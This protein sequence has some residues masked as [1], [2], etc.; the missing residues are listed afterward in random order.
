M[1][2]SRLIRLFISS[3]FSD[4]D[5]ER[6]VLQDIVIPNLKKYCSEQGW[7][8]EAIDLRWGISRE[9]ALHHKTIRICL[10]AIHRCQE[11]SPRPNFF[12]LLGQRYGWIPVPETIL[13]IDM[14]IILRYAS[15]K[16]K[17][18]LNEWYIYDGNEVPSCY[19]FKA[20][21]SSVVDDVIMSLIRKCSNELN[22]KSFNDKYLSSATEKEIICGIFEN[23]SFV[24]NVVFYARELTDLPDDKKEIFYETEYEDKIK[25]LK[26]II[27]RKIPDNQQFCEKC[28]YSE[29]ISSQFLER[30]AQRAEAYLKEIIDDEIAH[31][32]IDD[33]KEE[34]LM[35]EEYIQSV[36]SS[37]VGFQNELDSLYSYL[38]EPS[39]DTVALISKPPGNGVSSLLAELTYRIRKDNR[40]IFRFLG[41]G[42]YSSYGSLILNSI[43]NEIGVEYDPSD[44]YIAKARVLVT[45]LNQCE[46]RII[47][48]MDG[49][50]MLC[51]DDMFLDMT[52]L[53]HPLP[54]NV[55]VILS[56]SKEREI[57]LLKGFNI[58]DIHIGMLS[59][60]D[61]ERTLYI[62]LGAKK[63][64]LNDRQSLAI[65]EV[66]KNC[67]YLPVLKPIL[68]QMALKWRSGDLI[69]LPYFNFSDII[70]EWI[71]NL[72]R[73]ENFGERFVSMTLGFL[74]YSKSGIQE[75]ELL[76]LLAMDNIYMKELMSN[77]YHKIET[78]A[79]GRKRVPFILWDSFY[80]EIA[81][82]LVQR[83]SYGGLNYTIAN[84][85]IKKYI[86]KY[87][88]D[89]YH[90]RLNVIQLLADY[91]SSEGI[92]ESAR[93]MEELPHA[94][95]QLENKKTYLNLISDSNF[96]FLKCCH[97][98][99]EDLQLNYKDA[100]SLS[101]DDVE[102]R[103]KI[104]ILDSFVR[105]EKPKLML[106]GKFPFF[107]ESQFKKYVN[108]LDPTENM[109]IYPN[110]YSYTVQQG[111]YILI[112]SQIEGDSKHAYCTCYL[113]NYSS[114]K[115]YRHID[116]PISIYVDTK[117]RGYVTGKISR[118]IISPD[119]TEV[120]L[121]DEAF[122]E[123]APQVWKWDLKR[124]IIIRYHNYSM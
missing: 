7:Q 59:S 54:S 33:F 100:L 73:A 113:W 91:F 71:D 60:S 107:A 13:A 55:K 58:L 81:A 4:M 64:V 78:K 26:N 98:M 77:S 105:S 14:E 9:A 8:F 61:F 27:H 93:A 10:D 82:I 96:T 89:K 5:V 25:Q 30:F 80:G 36:H 116:V 11:L 37:F 43:L 56:T 72:S 86:A 119:I 20:G 88:Q 63:R 94:L 21:D 17:T 66:Y 83:Q 95:F 49:M 23:D 117:G 70:N 2:S 24:D 48:V 22:D 76:E 84:I 12:L 1:R 118:A 121:I 45:W 87:L 85:T 110:Y 74:V 16:E 6:C 122:E 92:K 41:N 57:E 47:L 75:D 39:S 34:Q 50:D 90:I 103:Q 115:L 112:C 69:D 15:E 44:D 46:E 106:Y 111:D 29:Y 124:N 52:W 3:T 97:E 79:Y 65:A 114:G 35:N 40:I 53:P 101:F 31:C 19:E 18:I 51:D 32:K 62:E 108:N 67:A 109:S 104:V 102:L 120:T 123:T 99:I 28:S 68:K 42:K 38:Q